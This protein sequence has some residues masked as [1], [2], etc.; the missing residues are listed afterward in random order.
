[1]HPSPR[2][3]PS[4]P[5]PPPRCS[6]L[7]LHCL[8]RLPL[9]L[10]AVLRAPPQPV[11][12]L[13]SNLYHAKHHLPVLQPKLHFLHCH[14][15]RQRLRD[16]HCW[17]L[18]VP[19]IGD[20]QCLSAGRL[21]LHLLCSPAMPCGVLPAQLSLLLLHRWLSDLHQRLLLHS[22]QHRLL[23]YQFKHLFPLLCSQLQF[24]LSRWVLFSLLTR[25]FRSVL[26]IS[27]SSPLRCVQ[28][29]HLLPMLG[30]VLHGC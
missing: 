25:I 7:Q 13:H 12:H 30:R 4:P 3:S 11:H 24:L 22:L 15:R 1:M 28:R 8:L 21:H 19:V 23:S 29:W 17:L 26:L 2:C 10:P 18:F 14:H 5:P 16:L 6:V 20:L 9:H 27:M